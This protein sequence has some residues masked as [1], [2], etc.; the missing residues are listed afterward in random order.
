MMIPGI[1]AQRRHP[2]PEGELPGPEQII[3]F[4]I[5]NY[6]TVGGSANARSMFVP[7]QVVSGDLIVATV[8]H[9]SAVT[10]PAGWTLLFSGL[11]GGGVQSLSVYYKTAGSGDPG[12]NHSWTQNSTSQFVVHYSIFRG[13]QPLAIID[14]E[15][16]TGTTAAPIMAMAEATPTHQGQ[17]LLSVVTRVMSNAD[18]PCTANASS[19]W[20]TRSATSS[21]SVPIRTAV[22]T[23]DAVYQTDVEGEW[24][25]TPTSGSASPGWRTAQ[26]VIGYA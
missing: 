8:N 23:R 20:T 12:S 7:T 18:V 2:V 25:I 17:M 24:E 15:T 6:G 21:P 22:A 14:Y 3:D 10:A 5:G 1:M 26:L 9:N 4:E 19:G 13:A 16:I 11:N